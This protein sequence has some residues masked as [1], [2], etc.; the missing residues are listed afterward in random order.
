MG[1]VANGMLADIL[2]LAAVR[3][4]GKPF[5]AESVES[6]DFDT[7][8]AAT[9]VAAPA[10]VRGY[11]D[12]LA[13]TLAGPLTAGIKVLHWA[14]D[15]APVIL[16]HQGGGEEPFDHIISQAFPQDRPSPVNVVAIR[17]P[18]QGSRRELE[19]SFTRLEV[20]L[21]MMASVVQLTE[22]LLQSRSLSRSRRTVVSGYSL[23]GFVANRHHLLF[24]SADVYVP[25]MAGARHAEI[26]LSTVPAARSA[27]RQ[28]EIL[29]SRL[30][31]AAAWA[32]RAHTN[33]FP[34]MGRHDRLNRLDVQGPSYGDRPLEVWDGGHLYGASHPERVREVLLRHALATGG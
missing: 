19:T 27:R 22:A 28:P 24:N 21:A 17:T 14:D 15:H 8:M 29:R 7:H 11:Q 10:I 31:F 2:L 30:D 9:K 16:H 26:F 4:L 33:V 13:H 20:Y 18:C 6:A 3:L 23:G 5:F 34:V 25:F 1:D 12:V 32:E